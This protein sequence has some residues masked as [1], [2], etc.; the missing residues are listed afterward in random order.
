MT[1]LYD[2][3]FLLQPLDGLLEQ[4]FRDLRLGEDFLL[5]VL[6]FSIS[7]NFCMATNGRAI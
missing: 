5:E 1:T 3:A 7:R 2:L 6:D 4:L